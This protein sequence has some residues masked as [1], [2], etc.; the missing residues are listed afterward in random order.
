METDAVLFIN[1][2]L[3]DRQA[4]ISVLWKEERGSPFAG[5]DVGRSVGQPPCPSFVAL[6][7]LKWKNAIDAGEYGLGKS[8]ILKFC[9]G[10]V[11]RGHDYSI[12]LNPR[13]LLR[14]LCLEIEQLQKRFLESIDKLAQA[15]IQII[16]R[17]LQLNNRLILEMGMEVI[18]SEIWILKS[19]NK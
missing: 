2:G 15:G 13:K 3:D 8:K 16:K 9:C 10:F 11:S 4:R 1:P 6:L 18:R 7:M 17:Y 14:E 19:L 12:M 5:G